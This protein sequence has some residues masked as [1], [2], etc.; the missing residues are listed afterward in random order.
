[1]LV[2][3]EWRQPERAECCQ[4]LLE[5]GKTGDRSAVEPAKEKF[6]PAP[7]ENR[8]APSG[9]WMFRCSLE[10]MDAVVAADP[11]DLAVDRYPWLG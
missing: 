3:Q 11:E 10:V 9:D 5:L 6:S 7:S 1:M 2:E 8:M 4:T